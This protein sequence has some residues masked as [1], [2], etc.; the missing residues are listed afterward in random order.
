VRALRLAA[1]LL[2]GLALAA[3]GLALVLEATGT[4]D[5]GWRLDLATVLCRVAAPGLDMWV[6]GLVSPVLALIGLMVLLSQLLPS[7][8][9]NRRIYEVAV[10]EDGRTLLSGRVARAAIEHEVSLIPGIRS[11]SAQMGRRA[12]LLRVETGEEANPTEIA[13]EVELRLGAEFW[14]RLGME[15]LFLR[16]LMV[17]AVE[18][19]KLR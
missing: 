5:R 3:F 8:S 15:P 14:S 7:P 10:G 18:P 19:L 4:L 11:I 9:G 13:S 16:I 17:Y 1:R 2:V 12:V 6:L